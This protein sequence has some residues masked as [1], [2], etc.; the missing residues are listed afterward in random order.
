MSK[1]DDCWYRWAALIGGC[2]LACSVD[3]R[4]LRLG[5]GAGGSDP[6][7][8]GGI[9]GALAE[10][11]AN[12]GSSTGAGQ[13]PLIRGCADLDTD[14]IAD[15]TVTLAKNPTFNSDVASWVAVDSA[16][17]AW[18]SRN[19]LGDTPSGC[20][21]LS[22]RGSSD[23]DGSTIVRAAQCVVVPAHQLV[24]AYANAWVGTAPGAS[25]P[26]QAELEISFFDSDDCS[27]K[28]S[29]YFATP[30]SAE[31]EKWVTIQ[32]GNLPGPATKSASVALLGIKPNRNSELSAC[33]DN[34]MIKT[35]LL[36]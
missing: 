18:D 14:G 16:T 30:P 8:G 19:A 17:L 13:T 2:A 28:A 33:F 29:N 32:A 26:A 21:L 12:G 35:K 25:N 11:S 36:D 20:A 9:A 34:V 31:L 27:G 1:T 4:E 3:A 15:C 22:A 24:I 5:S 23:S 6:D 7:P 10:P